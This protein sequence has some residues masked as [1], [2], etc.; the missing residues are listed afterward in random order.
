M[1]LIFLSVEKVD[2]LIDWIHRKIDKYMSG[3]TQN[4]MVKLMALRVLRQMTS[5]RGPTFLG[6]LPVATCTGKR[7]SRKAMMDQGSEFQRRLE[8]FIQG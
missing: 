7:M 6:S 1:K 2:I 4:E 8:F 5:T 3:D